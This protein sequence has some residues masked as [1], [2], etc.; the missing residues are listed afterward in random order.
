MQPPPITR[1]LRSRSPR[2]RSTS[3]ASI[4]S[5]T[6]GEVP[7]ANVP[8]KTFRGLFDEVQ[9]TLE[10]LRTAVVRVRDLS[11]RR[12]GDEVEKRPYDGASAAECGDGAV[13]ILVHG[14]DVVEVLTIIGCDTSCPL[15]AEVEPAQARTSLRPLVRWRPHVPG[16]RPR[17]VHEDHVLEALASQDV[18]EDTLSKWGTA[19]IAHTNK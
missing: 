16:S 12:V 13:V 11:L 8:E 19:Y 17:G 6:L 9:D 3:S 7:R 10:A 14:Q 1:A 5:V 18:L 15:R 4:L 2:C